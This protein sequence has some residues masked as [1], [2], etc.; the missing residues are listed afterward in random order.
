M[1]WRTN[2]EKAHHWSIG[3]TLQ[4]S[5]ERVHSYFPRLL[6]VHQHHLFSSEALYTEK[7]RRCNNFLLKALINSLV[8][9]WTF[10]YQTTI[11]RRN[12]NQKLS[13]DIPQN[14]T[15]L[16]PRDILTAADHLIGMKF[17][18]GILDDI[19]HLKNKFIR[20]IADF[21]FVNDLCFILLFVTT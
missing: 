2:W 17:G 6:V 1:E 15:F 20:L 11:G 9:V 18:M 3:A 10:F 4:G 12:M 7:I 13:L 8:V 14:N 19:N 5:K 16:L 21:A